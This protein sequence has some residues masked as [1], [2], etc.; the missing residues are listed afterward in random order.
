MGFWGVGIG[1]AV[2]VDVAGTAGSTPSSA[3]TAK[4]FTAQVAVP[5]ESSFFGEAFL[6]GFAKVFSFTTFCSVFFLVVDSLSTPD[7]TA[8]ANDFWALEAVKEDGM[9]TAFF[10][11][12]LSK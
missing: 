11:N 9:T 12:L 6:D 5:F 8:S 2:D 1:A 10:K 7:F 3:S 4:R